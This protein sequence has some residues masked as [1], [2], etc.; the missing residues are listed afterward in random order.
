MVDAGATASQRSNFETIADAMFDDA[1]RDLRSATGNSFDALKTHARVGGRL[2]RLKEHLG[3]G[4]FEREVEARLGLKKQWRARLM[5]V[6]REWPNIMAAIEWAKASQRLTRSEFSVDGA[7]ALLAAWRREVVDGDKSGLGTQTI[8]DDGFVV[9]ENT[10][11]KELINYLRYFKWFVLVLLFELLRAR[12]RIAFLESE[13]E[14]L[15]EAA[16]ADAHCA[17]QL[18][19]TM[20][21][22]TQ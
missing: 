4:N 3:H 5:K 9:S 12:K 21:G 1:Y 8:Y 2:I 20:R 22:H 14:R 15:S 11:K 13:V 7:L 16:H 19:L 18:V 10:N 17:D 6:D